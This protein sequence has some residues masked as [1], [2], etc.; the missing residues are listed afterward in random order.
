VGRVALAEEK[1]SIASKVK[2]E[3]RERSGFEYIERERVTGRTSPKGK[4]N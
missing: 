3:C 2:R 4:K 1:G